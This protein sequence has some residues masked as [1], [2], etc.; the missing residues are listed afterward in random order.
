MRVHEFLRSL[1]TPRSLAFRLWQVVILLLRSVTLFA[2]AWLAW[3]FLR[4][5]PPFWAAH[6]VAY[7]GVTALA[8]AEAVFF[9]YYVL[10]RKRLHR[11]KP[12][13]HRCRGRKCQLRRRAVE[14]A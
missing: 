10:A 9:V 11:L 4:P 3:V 12:L 8:C 5:P 13:P 7:H 14:P 1:K 2:I 6:P